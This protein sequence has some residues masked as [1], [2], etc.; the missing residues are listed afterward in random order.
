MRFWERAARGVKLWAEWM[1]RRGFVITLSICIMVIIGSAI[2]ARLPSGEEQPSIQ[3][4]D[5]LAQ[6]LADVFGSRTSPT[7]TPQPTATPEPKWTRPVSGGVVRK[8]SPSV[9]MYSQT[10]DAW[11]VHMGVDLKSSADEAVYAP[12]DGVV[13]YAGMRDRYGLTLEILGAD[14]SIARIS[15]FGSL[16]V[17]DGDQVKT[18][19]TVGAAG[20]RIPIESRDAP[21]LHIE[22]IADGKQTDPMVKFE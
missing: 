6:Q 13:V 19:E 2:W 8:F 21:H 20:G 4:N 7:P 1:E 22:L 18:G 5:S 11:I 12:C 10:L 9:P 16:R 14:G 15:G 17:S 3:A